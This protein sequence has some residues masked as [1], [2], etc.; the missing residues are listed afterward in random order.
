MQN[1]L[2][3]PYHVV[4]LAFLTFLVIEKE[5]GIHKSFGWQI[6]MAPWVRK[7]ACHQV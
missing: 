1:Q 4:N 2:Y 3:F 6:E 7:G 5:K